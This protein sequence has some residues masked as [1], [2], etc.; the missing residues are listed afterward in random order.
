MLNIN[1]IKEKVL[2]GVVKNK[3]VFSLIYI[4]LYL[5][6][7]L[8][9]YLNAPVILVFLLWIGLILLYFVY[10]FFSDWKE[11]F[12]NLKNVAGILAQNKLYILLF[13]LIFILGIGLRLYNIQSFP[14]G[15]WLDEAFTVKN[16][17][18][19]IEGTRLTQLF[20]YTPLL[21]VDWVKTANLY[22]YWVYLTTWL[23]GFSYLGV[24]LISVLPSIVTIFASFFLFKNLYNIRAA[25][26]GMF[27]VAICQWSLTIDRW[28]WDEVLMTALT[29]VTFYFFTTALNQN[30][31]LY[32]ALAG[33]SM[34]VCLYTYIASRLIFGVIIIYLIIRCIFNKEF[35][36]KFKKGIA[37]FFIT[38]IL[39][40][41]PTIPFFIKDPKAFFVRVKQ[42]A[43]QGSILSV[44]TAQKYLDSTIKHLE[45]FTIRGDAEARHNYSDYP[46]LDTIMGVLFIIG[47][48]YS[49]ITIKNRYNLLLII[50]FVI[51]IHAGILSTIGGGAPHA[52]R[53]ANIIPLACYFAATGLE[54][55]T[56]KTKETLKDYFPAYIYYALILSILSFTLYLN[57]NRYFVEYPDLTYK[58]FTI[59]PTRETIV[60]LNINDKIYNDPTIQFLVDGSLAGTGAIFE[61]LIYK[62]YKKINP[63]LKIND[64]K[65]V[66]LNF[67]LPAKDNEQIKENKPFYYF[68]DPSKYALVRKILGSFKIESINHY[69]G[70][71]IAFYGRGYN[72][73]QTGLLKLAG[74][75]DEYSGIFNSK[76]D[77]S[78][79]LSRT[80]NSIDVELNSE[81]VFK[82]SKTTE[83][84]VKFREG[85]NVL[86][87]NSKLSYD[88]II[89]S[90]FY[91]GLN[92]YDKNV[93]LIDGYKVI[94]FDYKIHGIT[95]EVNFV[96]NKR[97]KIHG[98]ID[99]PD[100]TWNMEELLK[101]INMED[102]DSI[103]FKSYIEI[104]DDG[105]YRF[106]IESDAKWNIYI[107]DKIVCFNDNQRPAYEKIQFMKL[108]KG[109][110]SFRIEYVPNNAENFLRVLWQ[111][112]Q[113]TYFIPLTLYN[114]YKV[115]PT[116]LR[117]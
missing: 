47:L 10:F 29:I 41:G 20:S 23:S 113:T 108:K 63:T 31:K 36:Q 50:W 46:Q 40:Y 90:V 67:L 117:G 100:I 27:F 78:Y 92:P 52:Y 99:M 39:I 110:H 70:P 75:P 104:Y 3:V 57:I 44:N 4:V 33:L 61:Y 91:R 115:K 97:E 86:T 38:V 112:P 9:D 73:L 60:A 22:L 43:P 17:I 105:N 96:E 14:Y 80:D 11:I 7:V 49:L 53:T 1:L 56:G 102:V 21:E 82:V 88:Q 58:R 8:L 79:I 114:L 87:I 81:K 13:L 35:F 106:A 18:E 59:E 101:D 16:S 74:V 109:I 103:Y 107:D 116:E 26:I 42:L 76:Y 65:I 94:P 95:A 83:A 32:F 19:L 72:K 12:S 85:L 55:L 25:F 15:L 89:N 64:F 30:K 69:R 54:F 62:Q 111:T 24:K 98:M 34:G 84:P 93:N 48:L 68:F 71:T 2:N 45:M 37:V 28:G 5:I 6:V 66:K 77:E 51:G